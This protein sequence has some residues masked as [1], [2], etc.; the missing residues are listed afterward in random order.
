M[1]ALK[2]PSSDHG[3][4]RRNPKQKEAILSEIM[5]IADVLIVGGGSAGAVLP[6]N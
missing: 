5:N 4:G 6:P 2:A 1:R 3:Q